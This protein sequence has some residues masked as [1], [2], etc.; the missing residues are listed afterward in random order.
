MEGDSRIMNAAP[1]GS[2]E[3][4]RG[5]IERGRATRWSSGDEKLGKAVT[6]VLVRK[7]KVCR[8]Q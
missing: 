3:P 5:H 6:N 4:E 8:D 7:I 1:G 2:Q